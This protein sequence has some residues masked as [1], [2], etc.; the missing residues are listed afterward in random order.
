M[1][2]FVWTSQVVGGF[3][4]LDTMLRSGVPP[5]MGQSPVPGSDALSASAAARQDRGMLHV[6]SIR[7]HFHIVEEHFKR[8]IGV[9]AGTALRV[10]DTRRFVLPAT[11]PAPDR[12]WPTLF[13]ARR[14]YFAAGSTRSLM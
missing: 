7:C 10:R 8:R 2:F 3:F 5:H 6:S 13:R 1:F 12:I 4:M 9:E 11:C 14:P